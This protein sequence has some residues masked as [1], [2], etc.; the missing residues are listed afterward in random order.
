MK[1]IGAFGK[2]V[3]FLNSIAAVLLLLTFALPYISPENFPTVS[4]LSLL[5]SPLLFANV[6][7]VVYWIIR[8]R[9]KFMLSAVIIVLAFLQFNSFYKFSSDAISEE[10]YKHTLKVLSYNVHLFNSYHFKDFDASEKKFNEIVKAYQPDILSLQE[11]S[12]ADDPKIVGYPYKYVH[13][14]TKAVRNGVN[15]KYYLGHAIYSKYPIINKG[16]FDFE[17][18]IN[19][20]LFV[21]IVKDK[22]TVRVYNLHLKSFGISPSISKLQEGDKKKLLGRMSQS[23]K[24]QAIQVSAILDHKNKSNYPSIITGDFNNTAFSYVYNELTEDMNDAYIEQGSGLGTTYSFD[25]FPFRIDFI[26]AEK[27]FDILSFTTIKETFSDHHP[28]LSTLGW[29]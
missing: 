12:D 15:L 18:A 26:L 19:N 27:Y 8:M 3:F 1:S 22:D 9:K 24:D 4:I 11:Y 13:F 14:K 29:N 6:I 2:F 20:T 5:V 17:N 28:I 7:F 16:A 23:F 10:N 21:D 25:G